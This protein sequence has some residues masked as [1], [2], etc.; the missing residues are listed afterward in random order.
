MFEEIRKYLI[1]AYK[2]NKTQS[3]VLI[4]C[5]LSI[6]D[7]QYTGA[8]AIYINEN[9]FRLCGK[10]DEC[11]KIVYK[12]TEYLISNIMF[13]SNLPKAEVQYNVLCSSVSGKTE[14]FTRSYYKVFVKNIW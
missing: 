4:N 8:Q 7:F 11:I 14:H 6:I 9:M 12:D 2:C 5:I 13:V 10:E 1:D 3:I